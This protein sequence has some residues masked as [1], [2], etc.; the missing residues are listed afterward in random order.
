MFK[1]TT[2]ILL[3]I[4]AFIGTPLKS[5]A[6]DSEADELN[7]IELELEKNAPKE[8]PTK[9]VEEVSQPVGKDNTLTNFSGLGTL[10]PFNDISVIQKRFLPK[11]GRFQL[12]GGLNL[13]TNNP[14]YNT[15]GLTG[16]AAYFLTETWGL[17]LNYFGL[18]TSE[19]K[20][21]EEL[22]DIQ[23]VKTENLVFPESYSGVDI[24]FVPIYGKLALL[25]EKIIPFDL[26]F[27][28]GYG[29]TGTQAKESAGTVHLA[30]G[31]IFAISKS[32]AARWDLSWNTF[33][34]KGID[35]NSNT[36]NNLFVTLGMSWFFPEASY[37]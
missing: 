5:F 27:S 35:G 30:A 26:Y 23:G 17:E 29:S 22:R 9:A 19:R 11:T 31:Q 4:V 8:T 10:A 36:F 25:N 12:F 13:L 18:S 33:S 7:I 2:L 32:Y 6:Q 21:T 16:K 15:M 34:A 28:V 1:M 3:F 37:R 24:M 14:F 20:T